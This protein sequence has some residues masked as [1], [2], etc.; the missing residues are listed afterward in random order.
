ML[1]LTALRKLHKRE[2]GW[3]QKNKAFL[4]IRREKSGLH[5]SMA[6]IET[7]P[8]LSLR[9]DY[10]CFV[11]CCLSLLL[12]FDKCEFINPLPLSFV[13]CPLSTFTLSTGRIGLSHQVLYT[14]HMWTRLSCN[15]HIAFV[16]A[17]FSFCI[18][19]QPSLLTLFSQSCLVPSG[20][21]YLSQLH[22][23]LPIVQCSFRLP[24]NNTWDLCLLLLDLSGPFQGTSYARVQLLC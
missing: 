12:H 14:F 7:W 19:A 16:I 18:T 5:V 23:T 22:P 6:S 1:C 20:R 17:P 4:G 10:L 13:L 3:V 2:G 8:S 11:D 15:L 9:N 24:A 21:T